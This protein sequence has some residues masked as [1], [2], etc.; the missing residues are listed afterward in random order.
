M[1][2]GWL[3]ALLKLKEAASCLMILYRIM[4]LASESQL[5]IWCWNISFNRVWTV[6]F[7]R[8]SARLKV[9]V[10]LKK[11]WMLSVF[12]NHSLK[13]WCQEFRQSKAW[14]GFF[15]K[16]FISWTMLKFNYDLLQWGWTL[17]IRKLEIALS[18]RVGHVEV[19]QFIN[20]NWNILSDLILIRNSPF[21]KCK[22]LAFPCK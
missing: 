18:L 22:C 16:N 10:P 20:Q 7:I 17:L 6:V 21:Y 11:D 5:K 4:L 15:G 13:G 12:P 19:S 9:Y 8:F 1:D 3:F 14:M 2:K